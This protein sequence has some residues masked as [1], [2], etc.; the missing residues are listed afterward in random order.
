MKNDPL[1]ED[2]DLP[3]DLYQVAE[4]YKAQP[5]PRP[6]AEA[7]ARLVALLLSEDPALRDYPTATTAQLR[8]IVPVIR[9]RMHLLGP[10][11][12]VASVCLFG[13]AAIMTPHLG[14]PTGLSPLVLMAP[15]TMT[16]GIVHA[17]RTRFGGL[18]AVEQSCPVNFIE[19]AAAL[20][21]AIA[22]FDIL[23]GMIGS[24]GLG[25]LHWAPFGS[26]IIAWLSPLLL[27]TGLSLPVALCWGTRSAL[28]VGGGPWLLLA[29]VA[30]LNP[31][32]ALTQV[33]ALP[34]TFLSLV[35]H[36]TAAAVGL[37]AVLLVFLYGSSGRTASYE[38][39][40]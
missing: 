19:T 23:I 22:V 14:S 1:F 38:R 28:L 17:L 30:V 8:R 3:P 20:V 34:Q 16:L 6:G 21:G 31:T 27:F 25:L 33:F 7:T 4:L 18:R 36:L 39:F 29:V 40:L 11:F 12:W 24:L 9:W 15:L 2:D 35:I 26:L 10:W 32:S 5:V 37:I 13:L